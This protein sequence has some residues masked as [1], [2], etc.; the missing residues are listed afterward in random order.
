VSKKQALV[1]PVAAN[2][3]VPALNV[4]PATVEP[5]KV[6]PNP[7]RPSPTQSQ[8]DWILDALAGRV[9]RNEALP[10]VITIGDAEVTTLSFLES[11]KF[12]RRSAS[13][14]LQQIAPEN[15]GAAQ[16]NEVAASMG[17]YLAEQA[18][19]RAQALAAKPQQHT[20]Q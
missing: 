14:A 19:Q 13:G 5:P 9:R 18:A 17:F 8:R 16:Y 6:E 7:A 10:R 15:I 3:I 11:Y 2:D 1:E 12:D 20:E 4:E